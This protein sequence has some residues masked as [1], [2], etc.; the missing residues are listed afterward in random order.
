MT[1]HRNAPGL[2]LT[3]ATGKLGGRVAR[4][5]AEAGVAQRL[6]VR[7]PARAPQLPQAVPVQSFYAHTPAVEAALAGVQTLFM[8]SAAESPTRL[9]EHRDFIDAAVAAGVKHL[10]YVSFFGA[11]PQAT[12]AHARDH[13]HTEQ[14]LRAAEAAHGVQWTFLRDNF[15]ADF[16]PELVGEDGVLRGPAGTGRV[17]AVAQDDIADAAAVILREPAAHAGRTY[18]LTGPEAL[19]LAEVAA[20]ITEVTG[21]AVSYHDESVQEAYA[22]RAG[23]GAP[24]WLQDAWVSTYTAIAAG[25]VAQ[26]TG[27]IEHLTGHAPLTLAEVLRRAAQH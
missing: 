17:A 26:T 9:Q 14:Y 2:A 1:D 8:V 3:G 23:T 22:S 19:S 12:F 24:Q 13:F 7:E 27:D 10:V 15:Y 18:D 25:E 5:L 20:I 21:R 16:L 11:A 4:R 6:L